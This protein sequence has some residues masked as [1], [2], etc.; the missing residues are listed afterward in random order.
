MPVPE[1]RTGRKREQVWQEIA[2]LILNVDQ[3]VELLGRRAK[4]D[5]HV[6]AEDQHLPRYLLHIIFQ[7]LI[8]FARVG[9][10]LFPFG[11]GV[12][13]GGQDAV[14]VAL[15]HRIHLAAQA[16]QFHSRFLH[17]AADG[18]ADLD[19]RLHEFRLDL[20]ANLADAFVVQQLLHHRRQFAGFGV[21]QLV[22]FFDADRQGR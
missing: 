3:Q 22:F 18:A 4:A 15:G 2:Q 9:F 12:R 10:L 8:T 21:D 1:G 20:V 5:M 11:E 16:H 6:H 7:I 17:I 13:A 19:L 14:A